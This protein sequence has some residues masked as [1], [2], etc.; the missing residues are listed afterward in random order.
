MDRK[1]QPQ[2]DLTVLD[3]EIRNAR[4]FV[5]ASQNAK[6]ILDGCLARLYDQKLDDEQLPDIVHE[7][8]STH[9]IGKTLMGMAKRGTLG[10]PPVKM[11]EIRSKG[12]PAIPFEENAL[13]GGKYGVL[14]AFLLDFEREKVQ[15]SYRDPLDREAMLRLTIAITYPEKD[16]VAGLLRSAKEELLS[17]VDIANSLLDDLEPLVL[18]KS[19]WLARVQVTNIGQSPVSLS[20]RAKLSAR[21]GNRKYEGIGLVFRPDLQP[22]KRDLNAT[23]GRDQMEKDVK[24]YGVALDPAEQVTT[25]NIVVP[26]GESR[27]ITLISEKMVE[28]SPGSTELLDFWKKSMPEYKMHLELIPNSLIHGG[29]VSSHWLKL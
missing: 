8:L 28:S 4:V 1:P 9:I 14:G 18:G 25:E 17:Q 10:L 19:K 23:N 7:F 16:R 27:D 11:E 22:Q 2:E 29:W 12:S 24:Q 20:S 21:C 3:E 5:K 13:G 6:T 15:F 26:P